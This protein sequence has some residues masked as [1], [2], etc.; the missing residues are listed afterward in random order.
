MRFGGKLMDELIKKIEALPK[1]I[2][3]PVRYDA[4]RGNLYGDDGRHLGII[5]GW[6]DR[7]ADTTGEYIAK[8]INEHESHASRVK[9]LEAALREYANPANWAQN[10]DGTDDYCVWAQ[11]SDGYDLARKWLEE[12]TEG[13]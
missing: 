4:R 2:S 1:R 7:S 6:S 13:E 5:S 8:C 11:H 3:L 10:H 9:E 12:N